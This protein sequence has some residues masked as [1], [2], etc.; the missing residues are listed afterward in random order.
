MAE[1]E[2]A[3]VR[4]WYASESRNGTRGYLLRTYRYVLVYDT[5]ESGGVRVFAPPHT[6]RSPGYWKD[7]LG[8]LEE[9]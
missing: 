9:F 7:R 8:D 1:E 4:D 6:S 2:I 3:T 5:P